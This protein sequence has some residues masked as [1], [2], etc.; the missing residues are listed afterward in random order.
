M[1]PDAVFMFGESTF[2]V[3]S[4]P[5]VKRG[6]SALENINKISH[7]YTLHRGVEKSL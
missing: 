5:R 7:P 3:G 1:A 2:K 6:V 4:N